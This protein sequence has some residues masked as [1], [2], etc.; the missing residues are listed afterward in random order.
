MNIDD[1]IKYTLDGYMITFELDPIFRCL[2]VSVRRNN[3][4][5][6]NIV[7]L[8]HYKSSEV[9]IRATIN[10]LIQRYEL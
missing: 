8:D 2:R 4:T 3:R 7:R 9:A 6:S 1:L 10:D 5:G